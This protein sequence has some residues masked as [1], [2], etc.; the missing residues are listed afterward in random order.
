MPDFGD[1]ADSITFFGPLN[2][3]PVEQAAAISNVLWTVSGLIGIGA[4]ALWLVLVVMEVWR[5]R[6]K[7]IEN[8]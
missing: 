2:N 8:S 6:R 3:L 4:F 7:R 5:V 1:T